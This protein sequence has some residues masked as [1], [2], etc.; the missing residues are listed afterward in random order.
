VCERHGHRRATTLRA[1]NVAANGGGGGG[2]DTTTTTKTKPTS[3]DVAG[4]WL[5][6]IKAPDTKTMRRAVAL[7]LAFE[8]RTI[9]G[10]NP[11]N[12]HNGA[13][14]PA[15]QGYCPGNGSLPGQ[16]GNRYAGT[17]DRN[18]A[19]FDTLQHGVEANANNLVRL[20]GSYGYG[21]VLRAARKGDPVGFLRAV[22]DSSWSANHYGH[23]KLVNAFGS[24]LTY[25]WK[26]RFV[27][28]GRG[29][30]S[31]TTQPPT[32]GGSGSGSGGGASGDAVLVD[33]TPGM[34]TVADMLAALAGIGI[35]VDANHRFTHDE[36]VKIAEDLFHVRG[37]IAEDI[38]AHY[39]GHTPTEIMS[40]A[41]DTG[42]FAEAGRFFATAGQ[43]VGFVL[44]AENWLLIA[45][46]I[47]GVVILAWAG[48]N[49]FGNEL[50]Q[51]RPETQTIEAVTSSK[52]GKKAGEQ[53]T[54]TVTKTH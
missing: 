4:M 27:N 43:A 16:I 12:L 15:S 21:A 45:E 29:S 54:K 18:V 26:P 25:N 24:T 6:A 22:Q 32:G 35:V 14:C 20:Q 13:S 42:V 40:G 17:G 36:A 23:K 9:R 49:L 53:R 50:G 41:T 47:A 39:Q 48:R 7:W 1:S 8:G 28:Y 10:N 30:S 51:K 34:S 52:P 19:V 46:L 31:G 11:W 5:R 37:F 2:A 44:D 38:I 33:F 3:Y